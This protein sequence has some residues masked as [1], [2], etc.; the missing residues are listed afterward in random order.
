[1]Q[2]I[3]ESPN[4]SGH[5]GMPEAVVAKGHHFGESLVGG[6]ML[7]G[8]AIRSY[9]NARAVVAEGAVHKDFLGRRFAKKRKES[10]EL[11]RRRIRECTNG[12]ADETKTKRL[13]LLTFLFRGALKLGSQVHDGR[14]AEFFQFGKR[15]KRGLRAAI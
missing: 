4:K 9:E 10:R 13:G 15:R 1:M 5:G 3:R 11:R 8:D 7:K 12:N 14:D 6:P 2:A